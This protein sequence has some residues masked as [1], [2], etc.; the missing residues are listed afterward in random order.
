[1]KTEWLM[2]GFEQSDSVGLTNPGIWCKTLPKWIILFMC[3]ALLLIENPQIE[4]DVLNN[5]KDQV[6]NISR[7]QNRTS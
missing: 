3:T 1:M 2:G 5:Y 4:Y 6:K 7:R